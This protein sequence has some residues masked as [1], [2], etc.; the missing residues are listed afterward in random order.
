MIS[1]GRK[2]WIALIALASIAIT[3]LII[4]GLRSA[5]SSDATATP[6]YYREVPERLPAVLD[7]KLFSD[8]TRASYKA[9]AMNA[10]LF[11]QLPCYCHCERTNGHKSL[12]SCFADAHGT[13]CSICRREALFAASEVQ[14][15]KQ[16]SE[17]QDEII[18]GLWSRSEAEVNNGKYT[19]GHQ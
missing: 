8:E 9:A 3:A 6:P 14:R 12:L 5:Q 17:I 16:V 19:L 4:T 2:R 11:A 18:R 15:G 1:T 10:R 7:F 13:E